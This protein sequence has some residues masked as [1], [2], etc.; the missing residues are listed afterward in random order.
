MAGPEELSEEERM[1]AEW[2][3][4]ADEAAGDAFGDMGG[5]GG[6]GE[7]GHGGD[8]SRGAQR[9]RSRPSST[10]SWSEARH[11]LAAPSALAS[12]L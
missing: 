6:G 9:P 4:M 11:G 7:R 2:A 5:G 3:A 1:A 8:D 10:G 12:R